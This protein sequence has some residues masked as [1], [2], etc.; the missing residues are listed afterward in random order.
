M[1]GHDP[2][3]DPSSTKKYLYDNLLSL[4][5][6]SSVIYAKNTENFRIHVFCDVTR[7]LWI[8]IT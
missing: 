2:E 3:L 1:G 6:N 5:A 7:C 4:S 8:K